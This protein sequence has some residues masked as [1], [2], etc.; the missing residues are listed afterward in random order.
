M[1][2]EIF[3]NGWRGENIKHAEGRPNPCLIGTIASNH[4]TP[5]EISK[6]IQTHTNLTMQHTLAVSN[7]HDSICWDQPKSISIKLR[8]FLRIWRNHHIGAVYEVN[9][10]VELCILRRIKLNIK[11]PLSLTLSTH[12]HTHTHTHIHI[13]TGTY[14]HTQR[15]T[16]DS[17]EV[18]GE[19][20]Q[21]WAKSFIIL[22]YQR[23]S[24]AQVPTVP[25][26]PKEAARNQNPP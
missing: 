23:R 12:A 17:L 4:A 26:E 2:P 10:R 14:T 9:R 5:Y 7:L 11:C 15:H 16:H 6:H 13:H 20:L 8:Y 24:T 3:S 19:S 22:N 21:K 1:L 25:S 18:S